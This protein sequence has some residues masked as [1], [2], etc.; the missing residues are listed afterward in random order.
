MLTAT[1]SPAPTGSTLGTVRFYNGATLLGSG[2]VNSSGVATLA[3]TNLPVGAD[4]L[5]AVYSGN[6]DFGTSTSNVFGETVNPLTSTTTTLAA[7]PNPAVTGQTVML[8]ATVSPAPTGSTL[9]TVSFY[10][11]ATLLG[12]ITV[13]S[14]G[15]AVFTSSSLPVGALSITAVYSGNAGFSGSTSSAL[16][17]TV[18]AATV[19]TSTTLTASPNPAFDG[20]PAT[21]TATVSPAPTGSPAG[22]VSF[23]S[24]TTL[25]GAGTLNA[26]GV[27]TFTTSS[28][29]VGADSL[30]A[31]YAGNAGFAASGSS[32]LSLTVNTSFTVTA[33]TTA[34]PVAPGGAATVD[35]TVPP[36][37]GAFNGV[38]TLSA[39]G[40]PAGA[41]AAFNP[42][43]V[44]PGSAGAPT[45]MT[46]QLATLAA[47]IRARNLPANHP[48][49]PAG[50]F[51]LVFGMFG[52]MFGMVR[53]RKH[54][55][56]RLALV[57]VLASLGVTASVLTSCGGGFENT[58]QTPAGNYTITVTGTSGSFQASTT[59][60]LAVQ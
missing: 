18:V 44:T 38:V 27:A 17:E 46:I 15:L 59:V 24:G 60:T 41:T 32:A 6:A 33:P 42:A 23:Y 56:R 2:N 54:L 20:Q 4:S 58:P 1:V 55:S 21:L 16:T 37:G 11:G 43:T 14:S 9:G 47:G 22:T 49:L 13:N 30:T 12:A 5:T 7:A 35:I 10:N 45:V 40:L 25:L 3:T 39:S 29:V 19:T 48:R 28:L 51:A 8:T 36:L 57:L 34:V 26:S 52:S 50:P 31:V 53:G